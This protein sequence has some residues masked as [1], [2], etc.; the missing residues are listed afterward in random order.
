M[1]Y[2]FLNRTCEHKKITIRSNFAK[3]KDTSSKNT[4]IS[5]YVYYNV[6]IPYLDIFGAHMELFALYYSLNTYSPCRLYISL[7][8]ADILR[9]SSYFFQ[10]MCSLHRF[11]IH[12]ILFYNLVAYKNL[13][14]SYLNQNICQSFH[15]CKSF[16]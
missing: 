3:S 2:C 14:F 8:V 13:F 4:N 12:Q 15:P 10:Q 5:E 1:S 9:H 7:I 11:P 6:L 16:L